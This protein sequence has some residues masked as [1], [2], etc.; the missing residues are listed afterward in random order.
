LSLLG[1]R[2]GRILRRP[3]VRF[4]KSGRN[5]RIV[6]LN[7]KVSWE[8]LP[9]GRAVQKILR[10]PESDDHVVLLEY[11][12]GGSENQQNLVRISPNGSIVWRAELPRSQT[13]TYVDAEIKGGRLFAGS[14][15][16]F[17]VEIDPESGKILS[18]EFTK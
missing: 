4:R 10:L 3:S 1:R 9:D 11:H 17:H 18:R 15:S 13:D 2:I 6:D 7:A 14:W 12:S 16:A 8:G 5:L